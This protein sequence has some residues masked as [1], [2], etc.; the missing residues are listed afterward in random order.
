MFRIGRGLKR[1][2][3]ISN[4]IRVAVFNL[5]FIAVV[6]VLV[7]WLFRNDGPD[8]AEDNALVIAPKGTIVDQLSGDGPSVPALLTGGPAEETLLR[9]MVET[10][11]RAGDDARIDVLVLDLSKLQ[12]AGVSKLQEL[13]A[14]LGAFR[15]KGKKII[16]TA[17]S[18]SQA[19]YYLAAH[20]DEI[21]M[22]QMGQVSIIGL[23]RYNTYFKDALDRFEVQWHVFR[24]GKYKSAVEPYLRNDMSAEAREADLE[25]MGDLWQ[26]YLA[27]VSAARGLGA[28][29][30]LD[31][32]EHYDDH[33]VRAGGD[34]AAAAVALGLVDQVGGRDAVR[35][36]LIEL[37]G[38]DEKEHDFHRVDADEYLAF[39]R[40]ES[41]RTSIGSKVAVIVARGAIMDGEHPPGTIGGDS[42]AALIRKARLDDDVKAL[43]LRVDSGG[44]SA[45]A[46]EIIRR[47]FELA[48]ASG[49]PVV[50]SMGSVAASGGYWISTASDEIW[51]SPTTITGSIGIF[52]MFPSF[53][54]TLASNVG[55]HSDGVGTTK[56]ADVSPQ[57]SLEPAVARALQSE[58]EHGYQQFL[59]RVATARNMTTEQ[60]DAVAQGRVWS[61]Q[62]AQAA[63]LVDK[64]GGLSDAIASAATRAELGDTY[65]I[66]Y[67]DRDMDL[68]Q[69]VVKE[70]MGADAEHTGMLPSVLPNLA[71]T[72]YA[73]VLRELDEHARVL[74]SF[75]DPHGIY[76]YAMIDV[77]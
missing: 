61:G 8:F 28:G 77:D 57:R 23:G 60:V 40:I 53:D 32:A 66:E 70:L 52:G 31:Y 6:I 46:S 29:V 13:G 69:R 4:A 7:V 44:G 38:E 2:W 73:K 24:V 50:V 45:F 63:G 1:A 27:D 34:S 39:A 11:E 64:L 41:P 12:S 58:I 30:L 15:G 18:Y 47:E 16:A 26:A 19:A 20:A 75:N 43:V 9:D 48:R 72:P 76:A 10:I 67:V 17:D 37:V 55:I 25:W 3:S 74:A 59:T 14:A 42:T 36:R 71:G 21:F 22:H 68:A 5:L 54:K 35:D 51:A 65:Q 56:F 49:K 62:D 33:V